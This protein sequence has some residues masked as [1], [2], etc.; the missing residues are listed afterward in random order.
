M[1]SKDHWE[2][3]YNTK[4]PQEVS[5]TQEKPEH[6]LQLIHNTGVGKNAKIIDIGG[7]DSNLVDF[8]LE[9]GYEN[10]TVL[11]ISGKAIE[12][13]KTRL[14]SNAEKVTWI[15]SDIVDFHPVEMYDLWHD[16]AAFHFLTTQEQIQTYVSLVSQN[17]ADSVILGTFSDEGPL[18]C[19]GLEITQYTDDKLK[20]VFSGVLQLEESFKDD[21]TTPFNTKQNFL[22]SRFRKL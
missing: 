15:V 20:T 14:G 10:L 8:L 7:G 13:A 12:R 2:K 19:S 6:S 3:V 5:W 16:R 9:L 4:Q 1:S 21:H 22:Y 18:K 17:V 11:D